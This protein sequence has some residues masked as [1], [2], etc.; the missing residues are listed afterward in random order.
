MGAGSVRCQGLR[1]SPGSLF[2][3]WPGRQHRP[4]GPAGDVSGCRSRTECLLGVPPD[5]LC[6]AEGPT[7]L[8]RVHKATD[9]SPSGLWPPRTHHETVF[10]AQSLCGCWEPCDESGQSVVSWHGV[11]HSWTRA[12]PRLHGGMGSPFLR[13]SGQNYSDGSCFTGPRL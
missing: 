10:P 6:P 11:C 3:L 1:P 8:T 5:P 9:P 2:E 13:Q 4:G 7:R 12:I